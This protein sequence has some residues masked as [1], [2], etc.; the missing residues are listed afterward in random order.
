ML[1]AGSW[2]GVAMNLVEGYDNWSELE[3][4][5]G[6]I[7]GEARGE[8]MAGRIGVA[9]TAATRAKYPKWWGR[10]LREVIL[11]KRQFSCW[12]DHNADVI[13]LSW[14]NKD[15]TWQACRDVAEDVYTGDVLDFIGG[16]THYHAV[17]IF[18]D[19]ASGMKRLATVGHHIFYRD[20]REVGP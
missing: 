10:N 9:L 1:S 3:L 4:L 17:S 5:T 13:R 16:P 7:V 18:P 12:L 2:I 11:C 6:L 15:A 20:I 14:A 8:T 19:W